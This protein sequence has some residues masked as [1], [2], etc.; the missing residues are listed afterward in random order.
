MT[1]MITE[2]AIKEFKEIWQ[3]KFS[4][5]LTDDDALAKATNLLTLFQQIY[6]QIPNGGDSGD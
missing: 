4:Q 2:I 3:K 5:E 6:R 1:D